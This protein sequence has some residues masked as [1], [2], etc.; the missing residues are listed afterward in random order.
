MTTKEQQTI[1]NLYQLVRDL[2]TENQKFRDDVTKQVESISTKVEQKQLPLNLENEVIFSVQN[3]VSKSL[4]DAL[5]NSYNSPLVKYAHNV[6]A[7][8]Q[9]QIEAIFDKVVEEGIASDEFKQRVREVLL[10]KIAK[11]VTSGIDGSI[12]KT[13]NL[14]KQDPIFRSRLTLAVNGLVDEFLSVQHSS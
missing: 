11:T 4:S 14:M 3:A 9:T 12:D 2:K 13:V 8:Y 6:V 5:S 1:D 7:R 10:H